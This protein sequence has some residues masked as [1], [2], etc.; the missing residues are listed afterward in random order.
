VKLMVIT[1][2]ST[3]SQVP[4]WLIAGA[5]AAERSKVRFVVLLGGGKRRVQPAVPRPRPGRH[6]VAPAATRKQV[7]P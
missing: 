3:E 5:K 2:L 6:A 4:R 7:K 1:E